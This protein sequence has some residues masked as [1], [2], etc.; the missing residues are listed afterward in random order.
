M[1]RLLRQLRD[2]LWLSGT[3]IALLST[4]FTLIVV[5]NVS[6]AQIAENHL[7]D[8][9]VAL[10]SL[11]RPQSENIAIVLIDDKTLAQYPYRSP[12]DRTLISDLLLALQAKSV[13]AIGIN[14]LFDRPTEADKDRRLY[15]EL[16]SASVPIILSRVSSN[17]GFSAEQVRYSNDFVGNLRTGLSLIY[18]DP[19]DHT[20]RGTLLRLVQ[21]GTVQLGFAATLADAVDV[22][23]PREEN[24]A[25]DYRLGPDPFTPPFPIYAAHEVA[26][27][28]AEALQDRIV[29]IGSD[30]GSGSRL[31]TPLSVLDGGFNQGLPGV[32][33]EAHILSQLIENRSTGIASARDTFLFTLWMAAI[34]CIVSLIPVRLVIKLLISLALLPLTWLGA[35]SVY[36]FEQSFVPMVA[37]SMAF[38]VAVVLSAFW[39]WRREFDKRERI[40]H[41]F[42]QFLAPAVVEKILLDPD[43][44]ELSGEVRELSF[45]FTDLEGFTRLTESTPPKQM[46][47][48][49]NLYLEEACGVV[50]ECGGTIDKIVGDALHVMFNAPLAQPDHAA[51][52]VRCALA[53]D[54]WSQAFRVRIKAEEGIDLGVTRIGVN[55]GDCIVGNFGGKRRFDY[56]AHGDAINT[57]ARLEAINQRLGTRVCVNETTVSQCPEYHFRR[58]AHLLLRGKTIGL[59][60]YLPV[61]EGSID[62]KLSAQYEQAYQALTDNDDN[63]DDLFATLEAQYPDDPLVRL[64]ARR[65]EAGESGT[66]LIIRK[67]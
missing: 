39:E 42:G 37:P 8:M 46:V 27:L 32:V 61:E 13:A 18:R 54:R 34:G 5:G 19:V 11:P 66:T 14:V 33:I 58:V 6:L 57:A 48:L 49:V 40:H 16:R 43:A 26:A 47:A 10:L 29:L 3:A 50:I 28:P 52:A 67:K 12:L 17:S 30:L 20:V 23:L 63:A 31:R 4:A 65:I 24:V 62:E 64:H 2:N 15:Q 9:Q 55:T 7:N 22:E 21:G 56:T 51:R 35:F 44:L 60:A 45:V 53:L 38:V 1:L 25:I 41:A 36:I 59:D